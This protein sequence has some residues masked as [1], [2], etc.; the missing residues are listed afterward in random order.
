MHRKRGVYCRAGVRE[1]LVWRVAEGKIDWFILHNG[2]YRA[3]QPAADGLLHSRVFA[4]LVLDSTALLARDV[5]KVMMMQ[6]QIL[7]Q[8][9]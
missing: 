6:R 2:E 5:V 4:G 7:N 1:Y 9:E 3:L 8:G